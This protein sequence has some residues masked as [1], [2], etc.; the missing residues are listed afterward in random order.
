[1]NSWII[2]EGSSEKSHSTTL[3]LTS[4]PL[5]FTPIMFGCVDSLMAHSA[6]MSIPVLAGTLYKITGIGELSAT[7]KIFKDNK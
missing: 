5:S 3:F 2:I 1:M 4:P 7:C 6:G